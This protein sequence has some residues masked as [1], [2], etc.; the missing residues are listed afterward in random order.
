MEKLTQ[1]VVSPKILKE[2]PTPQ[3][4]MEDYVTNPVM[5]QAMHQTSKFD[6]QYED[7]FEGCNIT[8][9]MQTSRLAQFPEEY[10]M[11]QHIEDPDQRIIMK[12][13]VFFK[14]EK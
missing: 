7:D 2:S 11:L 3:N 8:L 1:R 5:M 9:D 14:Y 12:Q 10:E 6:H 4:E 13:M